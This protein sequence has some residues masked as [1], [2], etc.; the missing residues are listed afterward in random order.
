M[1]GTGLIIR[2]RVC[3]QLGQHV[4][5]DMTTPPTHQ[6]K[7]SDGYSGR[8]SSLGL[9]FRKR[10]SARDVLFLTW[11]GTRNSQLPFLFSAKPSLQVDSIMPFII[12]ISFSELRILFR[13]FPLLVRHDLHQ[14][15]QGVERRWDSL[16][17]AIKTLFRRPQRKN[18]YD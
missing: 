11:R 16:Y 14:K 5:Y 1:P 17:T 8:G 13:I 6:N 4:R 7:V 18:L 2:R 15:I 10:Q 3:P 9:W 12:S